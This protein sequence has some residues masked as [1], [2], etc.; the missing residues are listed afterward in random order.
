M[1]RYASFFMEL[2]KIT[3]TFVVASGVA[4]YTVQDPEISNWVLNA[5]QGCIVL[6]GM[7]LFGSFICVNLDE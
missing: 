6:M 3:A 7:S 4:Y 5:F 1:K 2:A